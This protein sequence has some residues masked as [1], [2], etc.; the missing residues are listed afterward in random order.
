[1]CDAIRSIT[2][3]T[4]SNATDTFDASIVAPRQ[5]NDFRFYGLIAGP[6]VSLVQTPTQVI[7]DQTATYVRSGMKM[8]MGSD[9][10]YTLPINYYPELQSNLPGEYNDG[11]YA[12]GVIRI[13]TTGFYTISV[14]VS[15]ISNDITAI[16]EDIDGLQYATGTNSFTGPAI[17]RNSLSYSRSLQLQG[18]TQLRLRLISQSSGTLLASKS[19]ITAYLI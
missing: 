10:D 19:Y 11:Y 1:M 14:C 15:H 9:F 4:Y 3:A 13:P 12:D 16:L 18:G 17:Y 7:I 6:G 2:S 8:N 5:D